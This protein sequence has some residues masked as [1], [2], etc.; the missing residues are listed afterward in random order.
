MNSFARQKF[1]IAEY[2]TLS[3]WNNCATINGKLNQNLELFQSERKT[4]I[5]SASTMNN[6]N[7]ISVLL[8][9]H[10]IA[11]GVAALQRQ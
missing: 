9:S 3:A 10:V 5:L 11:E 8:F 2:K 1:M 6:L 4:F 7:F